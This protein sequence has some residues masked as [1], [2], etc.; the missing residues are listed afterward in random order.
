MID[1]GVV[2][3]EGVE[4]SAASPA[5]VGGCCAP[6]N[7]AAIARAAAHIMRTSRGER[8]AAGD[9]GIE[10]A[11]VSDT[12]SA[13]DWAGGSVAIP[14]FRAEPGSLYV[15]ATPI[16]NLRDVGLRALDILRSADVIAA[17]DTRVTATLLRRYGIATSPTPLHQH[18]EARRSADLVAAL[19]DGRSV[20]LVSDAGTPGV[21]DPGARLVRAV[22]DAGHRVVPI[23][24]PSA[25]ATA[26]AAA[27]LRA[28]RFAFLGF[29]PQQPKARAALLA[30]VAPLPLA[31]VCYEAPHR[32]RRTVAD[33]AAALGARELVV[34][35]ELTKTFE[36]IAS[37]PLAEADAWVA[38][39]REPRARR[40]RADR[41][42]A[43]DVEAVALSAEARRGCARSPRSCR[44]RAPRGSSRR[45]PARHVTP[46]MRGRSRSSLP[47]AP[48]TDAGRGGAVGRRR[49]PVKPVTASM[50]PPAH[51]ATSVVD[52]CRRFVRS[53]A[54]TV[55]TQRTSARGVSAVR[56]V[57]T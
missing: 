49:Q 9:R 26:V 45:S 6:H 32:V 25:L 4:A 15:V 55:R 44:R 22:R 31:L 56:V 18:N 2:V 23:P 5:L 33:L 40:V 1:A 16:G 42:R 3:V 29:L 34:A 41:R 24:G 52:R 30:A 39:R 46:A 35:R 57:P 21:S 48:P 14:P 13:D 10:G 47:D 20:A 7:A 36:T 19:R 27:G 43:A 28:E 37:L 17:E 54:C 51:S 50:L 12:G 38:G 8:M 53:G 11:F